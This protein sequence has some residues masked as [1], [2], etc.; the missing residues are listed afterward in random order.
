[1]RVGK[2]RANM[3]VHIESILLA[4]IVCMNINRYYLGTS[5]SNI[6]LYLIYGLF[7][8]TGIIKRIKE[9]RKIFILRIHN[10]DELI[11]VSLLIIQSFFF[12]LID[13]NESSV[14][15]SIKLLIS[16]LVAC[17][18]FAMDI[19]SIEKTIG[20]IIIYNGIYAITLV[21]NPQ[22]SMQ[23]MISGTTNYLSITLTIGLT[24]AFALSAIVLSLY[25]LLSVRSGIISGGIAA[26]MLIILTRYN[27]RGSILIPIVCVPFVVFA[28]ASSKPYRIFAIALVLLGLLYIGITIYRNNVSSYVYGRM[29]RLFNNAESEAR[30]D[31]WKNYIDEVIKRKWYIWGGGNDVS[32]RLLGY[33]PHNIYLQMIGEFGMIGLFTSIIYSFKTIKTVYGYLHSNNNQHLKQKGIVLFVFCYTGLIYYWLSF[34][35]S[36][37]FFDAC[38]LFVFVAMVRRVSLSTE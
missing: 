34:M 2:I 8:V 4:L 12:A 22:R 18:A 26:F 9:Q 28:L 11:I 1:M 14:E 21:I 15:L 24:F 35:K 3:V 25:K 23:Q 36:Y 30:I 16:I 13:G 32:R 7:L 27:S 31:I 5:S 38:P 19:E 20:Y 33:Y 6:F 17:V 37:S 29:M 10:R